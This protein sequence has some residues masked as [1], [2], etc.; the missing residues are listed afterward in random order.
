MP[1]ERGY[2]FLSFC[3]VF[4]SVAPWCGSFVYHLFMNIEKGENVYYRLLK[5]DM[6][7]I[8]VSQSF[9]KYS[10]INVVVVVSWVNN[11]KVTYINKHTYIQMRNVNLTKYLNFG[12]SLFL[13]GKQISID[14]L[15]R[16][17]MFTFFCLPSYPPWF[18][19]GGYHFPYFF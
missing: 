6:V 3:H 12:K 18:H 15:C 13:V 4:G 7:G 14:S 17:K 11:N 19:L 8:W 16:R 5:L 2:R 1:W 9:G 10:F